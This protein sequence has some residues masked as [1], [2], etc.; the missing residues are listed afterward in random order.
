VYDTLFPARDP[1]RMTWKE[2]EPVWHVSY[3]YIWKE[4]R[5]MEL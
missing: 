2:L 5:M 3:G 1:R 4:I